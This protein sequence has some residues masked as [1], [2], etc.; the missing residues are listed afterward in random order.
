MKDLAIID[1][2][3]IAESH[4]LRKE[5]NNG[6][7]VVIPDFRPGDTVEVAVRVVEGEKERIQ[8]FKGVVI[9]R[10]GSGMSET[11][12]VR[13]L[14]NGVGVERVFPLHSPIIQGIDIV[15]RGNVRRAKLYFL[16]GMTNK[17]MRQK[18]N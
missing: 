12:R 15:S 5:K 17:Q 13:K 9:G 11:F 16:R 2:L 14:S 7:D 3:A 8:K 10:R 4:A 6:E 18:I 1:E